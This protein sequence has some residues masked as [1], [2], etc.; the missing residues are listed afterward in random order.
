M[1]LAALRLGRRAGLGRHEGL[2]QDHTWLRDE[3]ADASGRIWPYATA[4]RAEALRTDETYNR[5]SSRI[6][7]ARGQRDTLY[8]S[9]ANY[10]SRA[11]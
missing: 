4:K 8:G 11:F 10:R 5:R 9:D 7:L 1:Q 2:G 3:E 6:P